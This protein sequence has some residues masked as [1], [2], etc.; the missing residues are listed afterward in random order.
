[1]KIKQEIKNLH[2]NSNGEKPTNR[3]EIFHY[4]KGELHRTL[5]GNKP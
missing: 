2:S 3:G 5:T 4:E 1:M